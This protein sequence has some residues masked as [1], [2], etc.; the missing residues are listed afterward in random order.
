VLRVSVI[1]A[2]TRLSPGAPPLTVT[3]L[4]LLLGCSRSYVYKLIDAE[5]LHP[6]RIGWSYRI[7]IDQARRVAIDCRLLPMEAR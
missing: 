7:P 5:L 2:R 4:A 1:A 3:E 6:G